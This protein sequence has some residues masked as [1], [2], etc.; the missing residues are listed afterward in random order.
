MGPGQAATCSSGAHPELGPAQRAA[1]PL[2]SKE[3]GWGAKGRGGPAVEAPR[4][5]E[6]LQM[7]AVQCGQ[8]HR[9]RRSKGLR[10]QEEACH[11]A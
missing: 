6:F 7:L 5:T 2:G 4:E 1:R 10:E 3:G 11:S 8:C 9:S